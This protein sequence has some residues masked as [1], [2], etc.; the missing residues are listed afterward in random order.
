[1][2]GE[3]KSYWAAN[4]WH[5]QI[6]STPVHVLRV[7]TAARGVHG[8]E[9]AISFAHGLLKRKK[10]NLSERGLARGEE[11]EEGVRERESENKK[12]Q[13]AAEKS[14]AEARASGNGRAGSANGASLSFTGT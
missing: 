10:K 2:E 13:R 1:M 9:V 4:R 14:E 12:L 3:R 11:G 7:H 8:N 6:S 5:M